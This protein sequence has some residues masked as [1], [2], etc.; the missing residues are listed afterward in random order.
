MSHHAADAAFVLMKLFVQMSI[1]ITLY[2]HWSP[3]SNV[4]E[5]PSTPLTYVCV[6]L[7]VDFAR[8]CQGQMWHTKHLRLLQSFQ[9][10]RFDLFCHYTPLCNNS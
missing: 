4:N 1:F 3:S 2:A 6:L 8:Q 10:L 5:F 9:W 7:A